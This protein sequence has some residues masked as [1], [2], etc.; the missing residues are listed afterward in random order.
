[1][2]S[3][4]T[5]QKI[6][7]G[8]RLGTAWLLHPHA[9][10]EK[11]LYRT[12]LRSASSL[13]LPDFLGIG[14]QKA[15]SAWLEQNLRAHPEVF[16]P[17]G[18][19][20]ARFFDIRFYR[21]LA[22]YSRLFASAGEFRAGEITP[23]YCAL[24]MRRIRFIRRVMPDVRL[25]L[26]LR[27]PIDRAWSHALMDLVSRTGRRFEEVPDW[28]FLAH[29]QTAAAWRN[30]LYASMLER[31]RSVFPSEQLLVAFFEDIHQRP[32]ALLEQVFSFIGVAC[33]V[34]WSRFPFARQIHAGPGV[35]LPVRYQQI[36][37][38]LFTTEIQRLAREFG[39]P[40]T[41]WLD[42]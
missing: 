11:L 33:D 13:R 21:S 15:G 38:D 41:G 30:G 22:A 24:P 36:L 2:A 12:G 26:I 18:F 8:A 25:I 23:N 7:T 20:E 27:N 29:F 34:N 37:S 42:S 10:V 5:L 3:V 1:M 16:L 17:Q 31:W 9:P 32:R 40:V 6:R 28:E 35:P 39:P 19:K 14:A 4:R